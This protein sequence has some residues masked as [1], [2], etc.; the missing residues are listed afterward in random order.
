MVGCSQRAPA[1]PAMAPSC[2]FVITTSSVPA[3][4]RQARASSNSASVGERAVAGFSLARHTASDALT[5]RQSTK[6]RIACTPE[7]HSPRWS[8]CVTSDTVAP[9]CFAAL[10]SLGTAACKPTQSKKAAKCTWSVS[11]ERSTEVS[12]SLSEKRPT[13]PL[14][15]TKARSVRPERQKQTPC[16]PS[17][18]AESTTPNSAMR[19]TTIEPYMSS[20][21]SECSTHSLA[22][23]WASRLESCTAV[24]SAEPPAHVSMGFSMDVSSSHLGRS[25][26][27]AI[28]SR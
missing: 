23:D 22:P 7:S 13:V 15:E 3:W 6:G 14:Y 28:M 19:S 17:R 2:P 4:S 24:L 8:A 11:G 16:P 27:F 5:I 18:G 12:M 1:A 21:T 25:P 26:T 9:R 20:P 10:I